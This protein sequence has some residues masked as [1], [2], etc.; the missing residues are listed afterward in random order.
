M[1][2]P[3]PRQSVVTALVILLRLVVMVSC[4]VIPS[5]ATGQSG[6]SKL[7]PFTDVQW[8]SDG[9]PRVLIDGS[10]YTL[11][12]I[13][14]HDTGRLVEF[15]DEEF[16]RRGRKRFAED[17]VE[18][19]TMFGDPPGPAVE[20]EVV[21][22]AS[23]EHRTL[24]NVPMTAGNRSDVVMNRREREEPRR[25]REPDRPDPGS[26]IL[27]PRELAEDIDRFELLLTERFAYVDRDP[28]ARLRMEAALAALRDRA[29]RP[30]PGR[31]LGLSLQ[32][33]IGSSI[34]G[35]ARVRG[36]TGLL[37]ER[38]MPIL[39][40]ESGDGRVIGFHG[41]RSSLLDDDHPY[42]THLQGVSIDAWCDAASRLVPDGS[43]ALV[44]RR[45]LG[46]LRVIEAFA[47]AVGA[48][49]QDVVSVMLTSA[50]G[51]RTRT[52]DIVLGAE[53]PQYG[54]WPAERLVEVP[55][56]IAYLRIASFGDRDAAVAM[57][58]MID[59]ILS[60]GKRGWILDIRGNRGGR[61]DAL[62]TLLPVLLDPEREPAFVF[63]VARALRACPGMDEQLRRR[64]LRRADDPG[65]SDAARRV[66]DA[67]RSTF[68]PEWTGADAAFGPW[69]FGVVTPDAR[70]RYVDVPI[71]VLMDGFNF[72]ASDIFLS[73]LKG[74]PGVTLLG[75]PS[76][77]GSG[78]STG[79]VLPNSGF[80]VV[81][82]RMASYQRDGRLFDGHG[83]VPDVLHPPSRRDLVNRDDSQLR[84]AIE[85]LGSAS[86]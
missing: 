86:D 6:Y 69:H 43:P 12:A 47:S 27:Q 44:R 13:N 71:I 34:D 7:A 31:T 14:G 8:N 2:L 15:G 26:L 32:R 72:S 45:S 21:H 57:D 42:V 52:I 62:L 63:N 37:G 19:L 80:E 76:G 3:A 11:R 50:D 10:W 82:S 61:R 73:A 36:V 54:S 51:S 85:L 65:L 59:D 25:A 49:I 75:T 22:L 16:G 35:H 28:G 41:D 9:S 30:M 46:L 20:L 1:L 5:E 55:E 56:E 40:Q 60:T 4:L 17:L 33:I 70:G 58:A 83:V 24:H 66:V 78:A 74:R 68:E 29:Q 77:G 38:A 81:L 84:R 39:L 53:F 67:F 48:P 23:G 18:L 79:H 64:G